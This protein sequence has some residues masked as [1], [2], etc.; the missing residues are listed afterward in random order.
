MFYPLAKT[1]NQMFECNSLTNNTIWESSGPKPTV[2][3]IN[4]LD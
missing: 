2:P 3:A 4:G 1:L